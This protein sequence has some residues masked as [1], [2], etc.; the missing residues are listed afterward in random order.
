[1]K[2]LALYELY[3]QETLSY[4][5]SKKIIIIIFYNFSRKVKNGQESK[6]VIFVLWVCH[7]VLELF[8]EY[9]LKKM[10]IL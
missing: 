7:D 1:M 10:Y 5:C 6:Q 2:V 4:F 9:L 8:S 3:L